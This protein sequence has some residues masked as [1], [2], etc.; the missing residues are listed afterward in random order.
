MHTSRTAVS[1]DRARAVTTV[2]KYCWLPFLSQNG[3][4]DP[5]LTGV[6]DKIPLLRVFAIRLRDGRLSRGGKPIRAAH[7]RDEIFRVAQAFTR[8]GAPDPRFDCFGKIDSRLSTLYTAWTKMDPAPRRVKPLPLPILHHAAQHAAPTNPTQIAIVDMAWIAVFYLLRPGEYC[9]SA[10]NAPLTAGSIKMLI[11]NR[12]LDVLTCPIP[13]LFRATSSS[14]TFDTQKNRNRGEIIAQGLS[15]HPR[16]CP[17]KALARRI[18]YLRLHRAATGTPLCSVWN[19]QHQFHVTS[20]MITKTLQTS[21]AAL[22]HLG[23]A[24]ADISARSMRAGG[25]MALLCGRIDADVIK[26]VGRW[27]SDAM[28]RYL[29][30]QALPI[31]KD[32][33][34]TMLHHGNFTL[35]PGTDTPAAAASLLAP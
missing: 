35:A 5:F 30:A 26:L 3:I 27:K 25:A 6:R 22:P 33:A 2:W 9:K 14:I 34:R 23:I 16:A 24:P 18:Q 31:A 13:D 4:T 19:T 8:V 15:G 29:H 12:P 21:A 17:T 10:D 1:P 32:L 20:D 28:F 11:G 7:V